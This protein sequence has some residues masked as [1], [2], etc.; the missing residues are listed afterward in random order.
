[1]LN[2]LDKTPGL[3][4]KS[5][6]DPIPGKVVD[7]H[8]APAAKPTRNKTPPK[9]HRKRVAPSAEAF[10]NHEEEESPI[11][12]SSHFHSRDDSLLAE[13]LAPIS[14]GIPAYDA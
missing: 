9:K 10:A 14:E 12:G 2:Q 7:L 4:T 1:M 5:A 13:Y 11:R 8:E 6:P 3:N